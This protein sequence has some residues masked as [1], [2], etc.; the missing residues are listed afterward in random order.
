MY[1]TCDNRVHVSTGPNAGSTLVCARY[2]GHPPPCRFSV[3]WWVKEPPVRPVVIHHMA[4]GSDADVFW[5]SVKAFDDMT[6]ALDQVRGVYAAHWWD[7][8][9][10]PWQVKVE[11]VIPPAFKRNKGKGKC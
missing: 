2:A 10:R 9:E 11:P 6:A 8:L 1:G 3:E 4:Y 7:L 5:D